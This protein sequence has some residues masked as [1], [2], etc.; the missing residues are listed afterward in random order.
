MIKLMITDRGL[1]EPI[2]YN[3]DWRACIDIMKP[4]QLEDFFLKNFKVVL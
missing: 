4:N 2:L 3:Y 1:R